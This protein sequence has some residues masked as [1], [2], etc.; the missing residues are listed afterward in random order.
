M[1]GGY[2]SDML[3]SGRK[4]P[5]TARLG[6]SALKPRAARQ[7]MTL[8][9]VLSGKILGSPPAKKDGPVHAAPAVSGGHGAAWQ[10]LRQVEQ[11]RKQIESVIAQIEEL[12]K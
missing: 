4:D 12:Q 5:Y 1:G 10:L 8:G 11:Q 7:S 2:F 9:D 3:D 6:A